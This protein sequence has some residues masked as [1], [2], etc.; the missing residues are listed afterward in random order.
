MT[1]AV[2]GRRTRILMALFLLGKDQPHSIFSEK[3]KL[4]F[5]LP[6]DS[7]RSR[8]TISQML[9]ENVVE[10]IDT[11][12]YQ[13][14]Q[15][16]LSEL[17]LA[18]PFVRFHKFDWD[19]KFRILSYEIP[20][21]KRKLRDSLRREV[22]G[23]GLGPWHRS[24]WI[25]P[26]PVT[27]ALKRLTEDSLYEEYVQAFEAE[28]VVGKQEV[29]IEKVWNLKQLEAKYKV[30]FKEWHKYLSDQELVKEIKMKKIIN[31]YLDVLKDD[32]GLPKELLSPHWIGFEAW[33][34]F[35]EMRN[36]LI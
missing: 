14:T 9:E 33:D 8:G 21:K 23:W 1:S 34:I 17:S 19:G 22:S 31:S 10:K 36:I 6:A 32:P 3:V 12:V 26:H 5:S 7:P 13:I 25:T 11:G 28:H 29:L 4:S 16:G 18:F 27:N 35:Q 2:K 30:V 20:E 15:N 24:F